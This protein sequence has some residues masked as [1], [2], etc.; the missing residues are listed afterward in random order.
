MA[1]AASRRDVALALALGA[2]GYSAQAGAYFAALDRMDA[3]L[4]SLLLYTF[5]AMVAVAA[6]AARPRA[7]VAAHRRGARRSPRPGS[8]SCSAAP[9]TSTRSA[10]CSAL[11]AA[12][13]YTTYILSSQGVAGRVGP[14]ALTRARVHRRRRHADRVAPPRSATCTRAP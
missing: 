7:L 5:P 9:A 1:A 14:L 11:V 8:C 4:L 2:V 12:A 6:V 3:S 10:S 13:V